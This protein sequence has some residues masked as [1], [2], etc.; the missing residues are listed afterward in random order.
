[1]PDSCQLMS[2]YGNTMMWHH[3]T[4]KMGF[5]ILTSEQKL[6]SATWINKCPT[7]IVQISN[8]NFQETVT[9][10]IISRL[11]TESYRS[12]HVQADSWFIHVCH[13]S[14]AQA[15]GVNDENFSFPH[16]IFACC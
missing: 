8:Q 6:G 2:V 13:M 5:I 7:T 11:S 12:V 3:W 4:W 10:L 1:M 16:A 14:F 15:E 9:V